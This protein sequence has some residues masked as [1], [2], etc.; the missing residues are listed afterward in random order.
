MKTTGKDTSRIVTIKRY[1]SPVEAYLDAELLM[2]E[3]IEC[4]VN[5]VEDQLP[6]S[7]GRI[8]LTVQERDAERAVAIVPGSSVEKK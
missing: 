6:I 1:S 4:S 8:S 2:S 5:G 3:G 7:P